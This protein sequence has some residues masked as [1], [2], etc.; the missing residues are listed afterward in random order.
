M[1]RVQIPV[2]TIVRGAGLAQPSQTAADHTNNHYFTN[3]GKTFLE[4]VSS[5]GASQTV[6]FEIPTPGSGTDGQGIDP[7]VVT[8]GAGDTVYVGAFPQSVYDQADGTVYVD[9]SVSTTLKFRA[10][11]T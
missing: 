4:I 5:D 2:E 3:N 1:A 8:V 6:S 7:L 10:Y 9:P 11:S